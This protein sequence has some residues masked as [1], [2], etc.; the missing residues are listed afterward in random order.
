MVRSVFER[1]HRFVGWLGLICTCGSPFLTASAKTNLPH[2]GSSL[3]LEIRT[4]PITRSW[5]LNGVALIHHQDFWFTM[6]MTVL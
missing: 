2:K 6:G 1:H 5:N 3:F 4:T